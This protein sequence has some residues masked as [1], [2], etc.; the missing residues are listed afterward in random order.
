MLVTSNSTQLK[1]TDL[2]SAE[3]VKP[4]ASNTAAVNASQP[5]PQCSQYQCHAH[6]ES[7]ERGEQPG[8]GVPRFKL[9]PRKFR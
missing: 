8:H 2:K 3:Q 4:P 9:R 1:S 6:K 5:R 7:R